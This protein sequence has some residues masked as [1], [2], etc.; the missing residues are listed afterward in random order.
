[1]VSRIRIVKAGNRKHRRTLFQYFGKPV[2]L[3][4]ILVFVAGSIMAI[5]AH[6]IH[7]TISSIYTQNQVYN[8][9]TQE[10][11]QAGFSLLPN[12]TTVAVFSIPQDSAVNYSIEIL[13]KLKVNPS[14]SDPSGFKEVITVLSQGS[15]VNGTS[16]TLGGH[17]LTVPENTILRMSSA[18]GG[19]LT[20]GV[21][22]N[23]FF[24]STISF[25]PSVAISGLALST[26][27]LIL[28]ATVTGIRVEE[29]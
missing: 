22:A 2:N 14:P 5:G 25:L 24:N 18:T 29:L 28:I 23:T 19:N 9:T 13:T 1:M 3:I 21:S 27:A 16:L 15:A 4:L 26:G 17:N 12:E 11:T 6:A 7:P 8:I 20:V 10:S